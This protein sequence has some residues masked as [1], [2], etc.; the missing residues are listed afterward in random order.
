MQCD[1]TVADKILGMHWSTLDDSFFDTMKF[2]RVNKDVVA[3]IRKPS[4]REILSAAMSIFDPFCILGNYFIIVKLLIRDL[5]K[6]GLTWD[7]PVSDKFN[8]RWRAWCGEAERVKQLRIPRCYSL[9]LNVSKEIQL[10]IFADASEEAFVAVAY[11]RVKN[12]NLFDVTFICAKTRCAPTKLLSVPRFELQAAVLAVRI[13]KTILETHNIAFSNIFFWSDSRTVLQWIRSRER[14]FKPFV[15]HRVAEILDDSK[16][17]QLREIPTK[18]NVADDATHFSTRI[19][20]GYGARS[21]Y[22]V[23]KSIGR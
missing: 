11:L 1:A 3:G 19:A 9:L 16:A 7:E 2:D 6:A 12:N 21:F 18:D 8:M 14:R 5:W 15:A 23:M 13:A 10:H 4:K 17:S 20:G 22:E